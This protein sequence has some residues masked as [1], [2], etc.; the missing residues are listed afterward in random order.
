[1]IFKIPSAFSARIRPAV[2]VLF[3]SVFIPMIAGC[4]PFSTIKKATKDM[5]HNISAP[6]SHL[7]KKV[8]IALFENKIKCR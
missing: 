8:G 4:S 7:K 1:M 2:L 5:V 6:G 3:V